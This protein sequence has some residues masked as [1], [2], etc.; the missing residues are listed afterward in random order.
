M[1]LAAKSITRLLHSK[2]T[3]VSNATMKVKIIPA[4]EDNYMYLVVDAASKAAAA[5]DPVEPEKLL[6]VVSEE[7]ANLTTVLTTHHHRN[8]SC[9][10][11]RLLDQL[12][13]LKVYGNDDRIPGEN[14]RVVDGRGFYLG[15]LQ[16]VPIAT[17][18]H[19]AGHVVY[20]V[21]S[22]KFPAVFTGDAMHVGGAGRINEGCP[23]EMYDTLMNKM[24]LLP[25]DTKIF[26]GHEYSVRSLTF[27]KTVQ[28][29][30]EVLDEKLKWSRER[31]SA[32][33]PCVP[34]TIR[35]ELTYNPFLLVN[36]EHLKK[37]C[38]AMTGVEVM[39]YLRVEKD[40]FN[41]KYKID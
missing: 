31:R 22:A 12:K 8:H 30:N 32:G 23:S 26:C 33:L 24:A 25:S 35:D 37:R 29:H 15:A 14:R 2:V 5:V 19:T 13:H 34:T 38:G 3:E 11:N 27:A 40:K 21:N 20:F 17:P 16:I 10:N 18:F 41:E 28:S 6:R 39:E 4:L 36:K 9:G 1:N 7:K